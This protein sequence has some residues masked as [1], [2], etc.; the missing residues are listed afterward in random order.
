[1]QHYFTYQIAIENVHSNINLSLLYG[2]IPAIGRVFASLS[3]IYSR[4]FSFLCIFSLYFNLKYTSLYFNL[5]LR[6]FQV[7]LSL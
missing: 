7:F 2:L 1:M 5:K 4:F 6:I 3:S